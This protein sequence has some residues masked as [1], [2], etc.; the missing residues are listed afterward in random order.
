[1]AKRLGP[2]LPIVGGQA[3]MVLGLVGLA[4]VPATMPTWA[5]GLLMIPVGVG[6]S[7]RV[8]PLTALLLDSL[9]AH[10]AGTASGVLN[11]FRQIGG[12]LGVAVSGAIL[13]MQ[14]GHF[15]AGLGIGFI[16]FAVLVSATSVACISLRNALHH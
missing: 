9:P 12:S 3:L 13:A 11:T 16:A 1:M 5:L 8:P 14:L 7:F 15:V 2:R 6:G 10:R 4:A